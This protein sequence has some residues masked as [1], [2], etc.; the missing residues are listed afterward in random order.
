MRKIS[1]FL[2]KKMNIIIFLFKYYQILKCNILLLLHPNGYH[3]V[4]SW[5]WARIYIYFFFITVDVRA[6]LR[7]PRLI[8][9]GPEVNDRVNLQWPWGDS[10]WWPLGSKPKAWPTELPLRVELGYIYIS[11]TYFNIL[12]MW[13]GEMALSNLFFIV[14]YIRRNISP[15]L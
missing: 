13:I 10:N 11:I 9:R 5:G 7:A 1:C 15:Y 3:T 6:S 14:P 12:V 2:K 4:F 8:P